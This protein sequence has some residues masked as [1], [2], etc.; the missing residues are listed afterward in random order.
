MFKGDEKNP[1]PKINQVELIEA[2]VAVP[3]AL[4]IERSL[5]LPRKVFSSLFYRDY[6]YFW[7]GAL[8]SNAGTWI[9]MVALG[10][11]VLEMTNSPFMLGLVNFTSNLPVFVFALFAGV[12]ADRFNRKNLIIL[13]QVIM[14]IFAFF[15]GFLTAREIITIPS[16]VVITLAGGVGVAFGFPA[17]QAMLPDLVPP[18]ELLN[19]ITLNSA[20]FNAARLIGPALAGLILAFLGIAACFYINAFSFLAVI[21]ALLLI[22]PAK[23]SPPKRT[24]QRVWESTMSGI[25]YA[26]DNRTISV[27]LLTI[28][29]LTI[30][31]MPYTALM[32][33]FARDILKVGAGGLGYLMAASGFGSLVGALVVAYLAHFANKESLIKVGTIS[34]GALL[35]FFALSKSFWLSMIILAGIGAAFLASMST[36]NTAIQSIVPNEIRGRIMSL[37][38][39]MFLGLMPFGSLIFG[40]VAHLLTAPIALIIGAA[41]CL[42]TGIVLS[43]NPELLKGS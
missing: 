32:P 34:M 20:Q 40:G 26:K 19:A 35:I 7:I 29:I 1:K 36:I 22:R 42:L 23:H 39:W 4:I 8:L 10:W 30:F 14:M 17:W 15:L 11:L 31:G 18:K 43:V 21:F 33:I 5:A 16:I 27:L 9:Q 13:T 41:V 2:E 12:A 38:V 37:F 3:Q 6:L 25:S 24:G 28:G